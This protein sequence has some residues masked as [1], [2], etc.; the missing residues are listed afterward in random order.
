MYKLNFIK[1]GSDKVDIL[2][3]EKDDSTLDSRTCTVCGKSFEK[4][5]SNYCTNL[6]H[7]LIIF[8]CHA[9]VT[10]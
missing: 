7:I 10:N 1:T 9:T 6:N 5:S 8:I 4:L 2:E 3:H